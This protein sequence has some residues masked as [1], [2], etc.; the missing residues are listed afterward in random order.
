MGGVYNSCPCL[1]F[2][3]L[4]GL[5]CFWFLV[6]VRVVFGFLDFFA[7]DSILFLFVFMIHFEVTPL[8]L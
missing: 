4:C 8:G 5:R 2:I 7:D 3:L 1:V 6:F